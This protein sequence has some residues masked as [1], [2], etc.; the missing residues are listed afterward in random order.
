MGGVFK[1]GTNGVGVNFEKLIGIWMNEVF[2]NF[3]NLGGGE[4]EFVGEGLNVNF[5]R[6]GVI[7]SDAKYLHVVDV[8]DSLTVEGE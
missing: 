3:V 7:E 4:I 1:N 8:G 6:V 5:E 2:G